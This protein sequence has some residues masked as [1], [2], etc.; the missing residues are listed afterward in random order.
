MSVERRDDPLHRLRRPRSHADGHPRAAVPEHPTGDASPETP[1]PSLGQPQL[2]DGPAEP[3]IGPYAIGPCLTVTREA[4]ALCLEL[5]HRDGIVTALSY[6]YFTAARFDPQAD[7][8]LDFIGHAVT[9]RG[10]RLLAILDAIVR[11]RAT[12][13]AESTSEFDEG[14]GVPFVESISVVAT[15]E[16]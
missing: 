15:Q 1:P 4:N 11:Q 12:E 5:R 14:G 2:G 7:L 8:E 6:H 13:V 10:T 9:I 3:M 16:R